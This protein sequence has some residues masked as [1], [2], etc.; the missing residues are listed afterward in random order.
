MFKMV[1][2]VY[3]NGDELVIKQEYEQIKNTY[4]D[5]VHLDV[6]IDSEVD[7]DESSYESCKFAVESADFIYVNVHGALPYLKKFNSLQKIFMGK[8]PSLVHSGIE[9]ENVEMQKQSSLSDVLYGQLLK[10]LIA[11]GKENLSSFI[12]L[13]MREFGG[14]DCEPDEVII[15][16]WEGLYG[17]PEG[18]N[19]DIYLESISAQKSK[20]VIGI[21]LHYNN[22]KNENTHHIDALIESIKEYGAVPLAMYTN[23]LPVG[24]DHPGLRGALP[25]Y[26]MRNGKSI[27]DA[28]IVTTGFALSLLSAPGDG[29][30]RVETSVFD[31]LDVP[32]L[33]AMNTFYS[34]EKWRES[35]AGVDPMLLN[36]NVY[37]TEFDGQIITV[38]TAYNEVVQTPYGSKNVTRPIQDR[39]DKVVRLSLNWAKLGRKG[40]QEKKV[41]II[42]HNMP[43]RAD[44][45]G[46]AYGLDTPE[47]VYNMYQ[48]LRS[49]GLPLEYEFEDG[50]EIIKKITNGLTNDGRFL[51][52]SEMLERSEAVVE[53]AEY[54]P[55]F[56]SLPEKPISELQRDWDDMPGSFMVIDDKILI[57]GIRN[58][59]LFIGLQPPRAYEEKAEEMYHSTDL[60]CPYQYLAFYRYLE[61]I[62]G[63]DVVVHVGTHGTIEWLPGK[64]IGLSDECYPDLAIGDLP[65]LYPYIIDV[66]G[67][68]VQAKRRT[69]A[70]ILDHLIPSM[71]EGGMYGVLEGIDD[72]ISQYYRAR[73]EN[74]QKIEILSEQIWDAVQGSDLHTDLGLTHEAFFSDVDSAVEKLHLWLSDIKSSKIKD[75]LHIFGDVPINERYRNMLRLL[76]AVPNDDVPSLREGLCTLNGLDYEVLLANLEHKLPDGR[77]NAMILEEMDEL[78]RRLFES[79]EELGFTS[80]AADSVID[81]LYGEQKSQL[82]KC[83]NFVANEIKPRLDATTD[84][85]KYFERGIDGRFVAPGPSGAPSRGNA[86]ILPTGRNF[87]MIDPT[88]V[89]SRSAWE[90][91]KLLGDQLIQRYLDDEGQYPE[92]VAIVVY[93]GETIKTSGDDIAEIMY[94]Y[95]VRP[96][97]IKNTDRVID[98]EVIPLEELG[99]P[100]IDV[101]LRISG[102]F[103][104]T[105]PNLI[106]RIEDAVNLVASLDEDPEMNFIKKHVFSDFDQFIEQGLQREQA[107]E[108]AKLR[109]FGCPPGTYGAGVDILVNSKKWETAEDLGRAYINW[110]AHAYGK[111]IHGTKLEGL[112]S[113]RLESTD[114]TVKNVS[115]FEADMLDSD[116]FYNYHGG[117]NAAV[118]SQKGSYSASYTTN[119]GDP[120]HVV[121]RSTQEET[122]RIMR[123]RINNPKWI[124]G[125]KEHGFR[126]AQEFSAMVDIVFGWDA[127]SDVVEDW[128]YDSITKTY[129]FD[130]ELQEWIKEVN[131]WALQAISERLLEAAKRG[132]WDADE[133]MLEQIK[134]IY[135][136]VEDELEGL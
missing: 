54:A 122:S 96:V 49:K 19:E 106:E 68:G 100:R 72:L 56:E 127:T 47:S 22:I 105:F 2:I 116:D 52:E 51:S 94:L 64:E 97:W 61:N 26:M 21:L 24:P 117:L 38:T 1:F 76:V 14:F 13:I 46:C 23:I 85:M 102:L 12:R 70:V 67:E 83:L 93:S 77:T 9:E 133:D 73:S 40:I 71:T 37:Q 114:V 11:G 87:Y 65:H 115:S 103:R 121:T 31:M 118:K 107:F 86:A 45:I 6:F 16:K 112:F 123:A 58:G 98:L 63:A 33:Q 79:F 113:H 43:P 90:T 111:N 119:A 109:V 4:G 82:K 99:R 89:P 41:A 18:I 7:D 75:G 74:K 50:Q 78:G 101:T 57:P 88:A 135:L 48:L 110:G 44:M 130:Q 30:S 95:G 131:P 80:E 17:L 129:L 134:E 125:L 126:G 81:A 108:Q 53:R 8:T 20:P 27:V 84:E 28:L 39:V 29:T 25:R 92:N 35:L 132:M 120:K 91:G 62:F 128:M 136:S 66:P 34:Y 36:S 5:R 3:R 15:P 124:S 55:W 42:L 59:N 32:V 69:S 60:V 104:D 10:Y